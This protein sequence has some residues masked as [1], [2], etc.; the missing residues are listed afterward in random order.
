MELAMS[1]NPASKMK[2]NGNYM[3]GNEMLTRKPEFGALVASV[4]AGWA[5][6]ETHLGRTFATLIGSKQRVTMS[7]YEAVRSFDI[8]RD[9]L[10]AAA[11]DVLPKRYAELL[12]VSLNVLTRASS[13]RNKFA[14][15]VWGASADPN[16]NALFL[17]EPKHFWKL[18]VSQLKYW[19]K[20]GNDSIENVGPVIFNLKQPKLNHEHIYVYKLEDLK[21]VLARVER[22][23]RIAD[24]LRQLAGSSSALRQ[25]IY[26]RLCGEADIQKALADRKQKA[27]PR[28]RPAPREPHD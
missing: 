18:A 3:F 1:P 23:Y 9:L 10:R 4:I 6:T 8:Q 17:V 5:I 2:W 7:M 27:P 20:H 28:K 21:K 16:L 22:A 24:A 13:D 25:V 19:R 11:N 12:D 26:Q 15:W 14:H